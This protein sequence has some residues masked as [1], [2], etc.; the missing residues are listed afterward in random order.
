MTPLEHP[1]P[2][3][4]PR[5][6][7]PQ[8]PAG[9]REMNRRATSSLETFWGF[10]PTELDVDILRDMKDLLTPSYQQR[11]SDDQRY[12]PPRERTLGL[13]EL[14]SSPVAKQAFTEVAHLPPPPPRRESDVE[15][16]S[17]TTSMERDVG[18]LGRHRTTRM[19]R[20]RLG[21]C[22]KR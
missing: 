2:P 8:Q 10:D 4:P 5:K 15:S 9:P 13:S 12:E 22:E 19:E 3:R 16:L 1:P 17:Y 6:S 21:M 18:S 20:R 14:L 7:R 11:R